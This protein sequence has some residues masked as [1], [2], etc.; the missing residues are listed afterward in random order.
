MWIATLR[1]G[2]TSSPPRCVAGHHHHVLW[3]SIAQK[4]SVNIRRHLQ[5]QERTNDDIPFRKH[6]KDN[7]K[8][9]KHNASND[10]SGVSGQSVD[11]ALLDRWQLT[12]GLEIHAQLNTPHKLF[13]GA[14]TS[15]NEQPNT[16]VGLFDFALP[17]SQPKFQ[18]GT[19]LP[20]I[21]A[22][23]ALGCHI[24]RQSQFDRKHY[25]YAD[26]PSGYQITQYYRPFATQGSIALYDD[27]GIAPEDGTLAR[28]GIKQIQLE[29][30]TAKTVLQPPSDAMLDFNRVS[31]PLIEIITLPHIH[32]PQTA[33]ACVKKIQA[34][35]QAVNA[36]T[37]GMEL[38]GLRADINVSVRRKGSGRPGTTLSEDQNFQGLGQRTEIK[39][40]SSIKA[41]E[42]AIIA[43]RNRQ[44][45]VLENGSTIKG[46][47]RGW[48]LGASGTVKL[49]GKEGEVDYR[50]MP[51]PDLGA[52]LISDSMIA[53]LSETLPQLP[54][55]TI[56]ELVQHHGLT[57]K[58]AKT[59]V[60]LDDGR[61][62]D[63]F[64]DVCEEIAAIHNQWQQKP[65]ATSGDKRKSSVIVANWVIHELGGLLNTSESIFDPDQ[66][67][68]GEMSLIIAMLEVDYITGSSA[69]QLFAKKFHG[70]TR[71]IRTIV[72]D[73]NLA[74]VHLSDDEY[75]E[76][77]V[78]LLDSHPVMASQIKDKGQIGKLGFFIGQMM[79][80]GRG[81]IVAQKAE[82]TLRQLLEIPSK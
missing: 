3:A 29:Q 26:Q 72:Q 76:M 6:F 49:R 35:L 56:A 20:A 27:D 34:V 51:D 25:F 57:T 64:D 45:L 41:V 66:V 77:A 67:S 5:T 69:K 80:K 47:T 11:N 68:A 52:L 16:H 8:R 48:T 10:Q 73:E 54:D 60:E 24:E 18:K 63:Y 81:K 40:L 71:D 36:V 39:N 43:E 53:K 78:G 46:E 21:R 22:A 15:P 70:D 50:Y 9:R 13:S 55:R 19:L 38:G 44:I 61:R 4:S 14:L 33:A 32:H 82:A 7:A 65:G 75:I 2:T 59:L 37:T 74:L 31:Q 79:R 42:D 30:D 23:L 1:H 12:V 62:L 17:G 28:I 58:D